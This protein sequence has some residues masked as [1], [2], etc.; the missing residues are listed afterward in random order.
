M[1]QPILVFGALG[2]VGAEVI[3]ALQSGGAAVRA[4]DL[5]PDA[6]RHRFRE[7][8]EAVHFDFA[9]AE[10]ITPAVQGVK[11]MF[12]MRPPQITDVKRLMFP[13]IDAARTVG[14]EQ[15][16]FLSLIGI[17]S[18]RRAPHYKVEQH[19]RGSGIAWTFLRASFFMQNLNTTH[20]AEIRE[21]NE[22]CVPVG[23]GKTSFIDVRDIGAVAAL[24]LTQAGHAN[25]AYDLTGAQA[26]D[27]YEATEQFSQVLGRSITYQNL[28]LLRFVWESLRYGR[29]LPFTLVMAWLYRKT[30]KGMSAQVTG[31]VQRLLGR[32][33]ISLRQ[34]IEDY[35]SAW[36]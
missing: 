35:R 7:S 1:S 9:K 33:P 31:E 18:N 26:L 3:K 8:L 13:V 11:G 32:P 21:R 34:Y 19:L 5:N 4:A 17:E 22:I 28:S 2:N 24:A 12:L 10:T 14:V 15:V 6:I 27:Y 29:P 36:M 23:L 25:Q 16:V 30:R 20:R